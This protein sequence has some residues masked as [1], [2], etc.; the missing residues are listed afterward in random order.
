M[1]KARKCLVV[2]GGLASYNQHLKDI[3]KAI[4]QTLMTPYNQL[5]GDL[6]TMPKPP[7]PLTQEEPMYP[8]GNYNTNLY[9]E[10][11]NDLQH[12]NKTKA[13]ILWAGTRNHIID[14]DDFWCIAKKT[15]YDSGFGCQEVAKDLI[16]VGKDFWLERHEYDGAENWEFR[17]YPQKPE[18]QIK[19]TALAST[20][21][22]RSDCDLAELQEKPD[23]CKGE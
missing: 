17:T 5:V 7:K 4:Q 8:I 9:E 11:I 16:L 21:S 18:K 10:T 13:D 2:G 19:T 6:T 12:N 3:H 22:Q 15:N 14:I 20:P 23:D 1:C